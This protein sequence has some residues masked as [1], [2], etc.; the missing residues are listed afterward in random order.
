MLTLKQAR[1]E[2]PPPAGAA[3]LPSRVN[4]PASELY[5]AGLS[6]GVPEGGKSA[7]ETL[8]AGWVLST[9]K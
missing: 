1:P 2:A 9:R 8:T 4:V 7:E 5:F 3:S 6:L